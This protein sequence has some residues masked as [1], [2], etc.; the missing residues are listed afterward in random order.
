MMIYYGNFSLGAWIYLVLHGSY[1]M[2][3]VFKDLVFPDKTFQIK[4]TFVSTIVLAIVLLLYFLPGYQMAS[5]IADNNPSIE[6][7]IVAFTS[8]LFGLFL[9]IG[10]DLQKYYCLKYRPGKLIDYGFFKITRNPNY[11]GEVLIY[12]SFA[13]IVN[14]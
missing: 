3:W 5:G 13:I 1:G 14:K 8:Y 2:L 6:R 9:M 4:I 7:I 10:S 11:F 12:N